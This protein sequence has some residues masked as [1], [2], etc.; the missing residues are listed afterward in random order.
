MKNEIKKYL[1]LGAIAAAS[2]FMVACDGDDGDNGATGATG[3]SG[4]TKDLAIA[5]PLA[6]QIPLS[7]ISAIVDT[8]TPGSSAAWSDAAIITPADKFTVDFDS[9]HF[10]DIVENVTNAPVNTTASPISYTVTGEKT[11]TLVYGLGTG[12]EITVDFN[13]TDS[14]DYTLI[15]NFV[16]GA[17]IRVQSLNINADP[18]NLATTTGAPVSTITSGAFGDGAG[19][20]ELTSGSGAT[21]TSQFQLPDGVVALAVVNGPNGEV[22]VRNENAADDLAN[23]LIDANA[24]D[25]AAVITEVKV[26]NGVITAGAIGPDWSKIVVVAGVEADAIAGTFRI[27]MDPSQG[28]FSFIQAAELND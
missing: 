10:A 22:Y 8:V 7:R 16:S 5:A 24:F 18:T 9:V 28:G 6:T 17:S 11:F 1:S 27:D 20:A 14:E 4:A 3:E 23:N 2:T 21:L 13:V 19:I 25:A 12:T 26:E 15:G